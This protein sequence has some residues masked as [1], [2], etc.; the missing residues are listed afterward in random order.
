MQNKRYTYLDRVAERAFQAHTDCNHKYA[1]DLPY[2]FHLKMAAAVADQFKHL[3]SGKRE[4][5]VVEADLM[6]SDYEIAKSAVYFHDAIEDAR[7]TYND[8]RKLIG[9][10]AADAVYAVTNEKGKN[11]AERAN[12]KYYQGIRETPL[13]TF[14][15]LCDRIANVKYGQMVRSRMAEMYGKENPDFVK[16][17]GYNEE[18]P[19]AEMFDHLN[20]LFK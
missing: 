19:L 4:H 6:L 17:L 16:K 5:Y 10:M 8:V 7:M 14:V 13:S 15:K 11:R 2:S 20:D 18:H 3:L 9:E 12:D 1:A